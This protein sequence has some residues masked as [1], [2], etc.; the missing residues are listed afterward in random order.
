MLGMT[1]YYSSGVSKCQQ[2]LNHI[3]Y[4]EARTER[5]QAS[6]AF[7]DC[8]LAEG[9]TVGP[10]VIKMVGYTPMFHTRFVMKFSP[11]LKIST[12]FV[13]SS[14]SGFPKTL[15]FLAMGTEATS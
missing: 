6:K 4:A 7:V 15:P 5:F 8:K 1:T 11:A 2:A 12:R 9:A 13:V 3:F 10:H 14:S